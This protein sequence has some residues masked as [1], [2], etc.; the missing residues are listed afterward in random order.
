MKE[1]VEDLFAHVKDYIQ[2]QKE[3]FLLNLQI[4]TVQT[5][6]HFLMFVLMVLAALSALFFLNIALALWLGE[7]LGSTAKGFMWTGLAYFAGMLVLFLLKK[8]LIK[9]K[10]YYLIINRITRSMY[11]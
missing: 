3:L 2:T 10:F 4:R 9:N 6:S 5:A 8:F 1:N 7:R 11:E